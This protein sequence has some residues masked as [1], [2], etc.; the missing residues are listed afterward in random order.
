MATAPRG[1]RYYGFGSLSGYGQA[2]VAYVRAL[3]NA[4][5]AVQWIPLDW[6]TQRMQAG[7]WILPDGRRQLLLEKCGTL[8]QLADVPALVERTRAPVAHDVVVVHAPPIRPS[9]SRQPPA[10]GALDWGGFGLMPVA[11]HVPRWDASVPAWDPRGSR[12]AY[13]ARAF[14]TASRAFPSV[15]RCWHRH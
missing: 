13:G 9:A 4:G 11:C 7:S 15:A 2:A 8:G 5:I 1:V 12:R 6:T 14:T 3:V 10:A